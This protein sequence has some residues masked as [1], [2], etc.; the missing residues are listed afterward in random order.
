MQEARQ[1]T[2]EWITGDSVW[3]PVEFNAKLFRVWL[4]DGGNAPVLW[5]PKHL[6]V[7]SAAPDTPPWKTINLRDYCQPQ[8]FMLRFWHIGKN[9]VVLHIFMVYVC[10]LILGVFL[11]ACVLLLSVRQQR[12]NRAAEFALSGTE[13]RAI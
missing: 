2:M 1:N 12:A 4:S 7:W 8:S 3:N 10:S 6:W 9:G 11:L 5:T 13:V